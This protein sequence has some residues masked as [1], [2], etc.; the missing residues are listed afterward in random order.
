MRWWGGR[1]WIVCYGDGMSVGTEW[2]GDEEVCGDC[3]FIKSYT[4]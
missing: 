3:D 2:C 4:M 1:V